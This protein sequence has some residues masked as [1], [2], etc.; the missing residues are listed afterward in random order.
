M[1]NEQ[2]N[3]QVVRQMFAA[4]DRRDLSGALNTLAGDV[5]WQSPVTRAESKET[6]WSKP[7]HSREEVAL[8]FKELFEKVQPE[9]L[10]PLD[11]TAQGDRVI[12][13]GKNRGTVRSTGRPYEHD[14]VMVFT[15]REGKIKK[16]LHYYD[17]ADI[18]AAFRGE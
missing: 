18:M 16:L 10:E 3:V 17:T 7:R 11:F 5:Y 4:F 14:W 8:F 15:L 2:E 6:S 9:R 13:E 1:M 12:V